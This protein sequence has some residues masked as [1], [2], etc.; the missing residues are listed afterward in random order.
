MT[1]CVIF[2]V[3]SSPTYQL[4]TKSKNSKN[5][6]PVKEAP[7]VDPEP[8]SDISNFHVP[9]IIANNNGNITANDK[10]ALST[11]PPVDSGI[12]SD[13]S[14]ELEKLLKLFL[15]KFLIDFVFNRN[16]ASQ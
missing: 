13:F 9:N 11:E 8:T 5:K 2:I 16:I 15:Y 14:I 12:Y 4:S 10:E 3:F 7:L 6:C 1:C